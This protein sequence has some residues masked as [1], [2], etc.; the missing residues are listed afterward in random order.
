MFAEPAATASLDSTGMENE[1]TWLLYPPDGACSACAAVIAVPVNVT[2]TCTGPYRVCTVEPT[3]TV[4]TG[5][6]GG[7]AG[8]AGF[9][10]GAG[11]VVRVGVA[12]GV[13]VGDGRCVG[14]VAVRDGVGDGVA[15]GC[16][17][18]PQL[19]LLPVAVGVDDGVATAAATGAPVAAPW[20][21][22]ACR[23]GVVVKNRTPAAAPMVTSVAAYRAEPR[24][25]GVIGRSP[26]ALRRSGSARSSSWGPRHQPILRGF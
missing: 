3:T 25:G 5:A 15:D 14:T 9:G 22:A 18:R 6:G 10:A 2:C 13:A 12:V 4:V 11:A 23:S 19:R 26:G 1:L 7:G 16:G 17:P 21:A 24:D 20:A 8:A